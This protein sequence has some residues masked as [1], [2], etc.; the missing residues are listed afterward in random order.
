MENAEG[1]GGAG[2]ENL[3]FLRSGILTTVSLPVY[4]CQ[5]VAIS[6]GGAMDCFSMQRGNLML[7]N[8]PGSLAL[9]ILV[10]PEI[11]ILTP[12]HFVLTGARYQAR[13]HSHGEAR[14][15]EHSRVYYVE[16]GERIIFG[17]RQY[18]LRAYFCYRACFAG[19]KIRR[20]TAA[21]PFA[22]C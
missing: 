3:R 5:D 12:G 14:D 15:V 16:P 21:M 9:E 1:I 2:L 6:P 22:R 19:E 20:I 10:P 18:G 7:G 4:G 17:E 13:I 11:E 8:P